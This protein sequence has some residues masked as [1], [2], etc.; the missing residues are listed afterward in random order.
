[1][2]KS[3]RRALSKQ[4]FGDTAKK[5]NGVETAAGITGIEQVIHFDPFAKSKRGRQ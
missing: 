5:L 3:E 1:M 4:L 2:S